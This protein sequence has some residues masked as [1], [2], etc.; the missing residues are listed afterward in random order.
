MRNMIFLN[1]L[2]YLPEHSSSIDGIVV[3]AQ[4]KSA[5]TAGAVS[6]IS[7]SIALSAWQALNSIPET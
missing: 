5:R 7:P 1:Q 2:H 3:T 6:I 4:S